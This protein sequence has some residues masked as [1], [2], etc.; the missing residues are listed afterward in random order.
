MDQLLESMYN[1]INRVADGTNLGF[2]APTLEFLYDVGDIAVKVG[3][4]PT[5]RRR[6]LQ[7]GDQVNQAVL[8]TDAVGTI[9]VPFMDVSQAACGL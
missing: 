7:G 5:T 8:D 3:I 1:M 9:V 4:P 6:L 2:T